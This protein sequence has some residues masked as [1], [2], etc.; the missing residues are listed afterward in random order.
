M[1]NTLIYA[2]N[3]EYSLKQ[4]SQLCPF[5]VIL[6]KFGSLSHEQVDWRIQLK[7]LLSSNEVHI[8]TQGLCDFVYAVGFSNNKV[9]AVEIR[10]KHSSAEGK[11]VGRLSDDDRVIGLRKLNGFEIGGWRELIVLIFCVV[12]NA[13]S[14]T[15][16]YSKFEHSR[17]GVEIGLDQRRKWGKLGGSNPSSIGSVG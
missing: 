4:R 6:M 12:K 8:A 15:S 7:D 14:R 3:D 5:L 17:I 9:S 10:V 2:T 13:L 16:S 1:L 11:F